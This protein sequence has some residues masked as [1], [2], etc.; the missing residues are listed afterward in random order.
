MCY[1]FTPAETVRSQLPNRS[2]KK[3]AETWLA[4]PG[5]AVVPGRTGHCRDGWLGLPP[6]P[7]R[8][9]KSLR[10]RHDMKTNQTNLN[11]GIEI[12][13]AAGGDRIPSRLTGPPPLIRHRRQEWL[14]VLRRLI[15]VRDGRLANQKATKDTQRKRIPSARRL[16]MR[17]EPAA[18][19][20][21]KT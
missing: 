9:Q 6:P 11:L 7:D 20:K 8:K 17:R 5:L 18:R 15:A 4:W 13:N 14:E 16:L 1:A 21:S 10:D 19:S 12:P 3:N 2:I